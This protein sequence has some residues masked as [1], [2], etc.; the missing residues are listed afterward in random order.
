MTEL[1]SGLKINMKKENT[2]TVNVNVDDD[3]MLDLDGPNEMLSSNETITDTVQIEKIQ[4]KNDVVEHIDKLVKTNNENVVLK[5]LR[6]LFVDLN[7]IEPH[8][9]FQSQCILNEPNGLKIVLN[10][11]NDKPR[12]DVAVLVLTTTNYNSQPI[13]NYQIEA[14][15][16]KVC[17][18]NLKKLI[19]C[20]LIKKIFYF[21]F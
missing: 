17:L 2:E 18:F 11:V 10:F 13:L 5:P 12:D 8:K 4:S 7:N 19:Q 3:K 9:M 16:S 21:V 1:V 15:V 6:D 20:L 14:S